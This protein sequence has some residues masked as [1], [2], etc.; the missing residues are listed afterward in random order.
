MFL[1]SQ[2]L[3]V[4]GLKSFFTTSLAVAGNLGGSMEAEHNF[5]RRIQPIGSTLN[6]IQLQQPN[7]EMRSEEIHDSDNYRA[8]IAY[9][10]GGYYLE[11][12]VF[13]PS[14]DNGTLLEII[15]R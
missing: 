2:K 3:S 5:G 10:P 9:D 15:A 11:W 1:C 12:D 4:K 8:F 6:L 7:V 14:D 13:K